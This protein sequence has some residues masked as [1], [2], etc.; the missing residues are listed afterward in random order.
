VEVQS[1]TRAE[2]EYLKLV[3]QLS[4]KLIKIKYLLVIYNEHPAFTI[5][6]NKTINLDMPISLYGNNG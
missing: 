3:N 1:A 4:N 2:H 5:Y 6:L